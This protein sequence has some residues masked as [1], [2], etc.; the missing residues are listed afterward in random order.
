MPWFKA[1]DSKQKAQ[2]TQKEKKSFP[3]EIVEN[4][5][6]HKSVLNKIMATQEWCEK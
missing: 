6:L 3:K 1:F 4:E 2:K 5:D